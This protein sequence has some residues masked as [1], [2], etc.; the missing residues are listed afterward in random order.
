MD[1]LKKHVV[2][3]VKSLTPA[4]VLKSYTGRPGCMCGCKGTYRVTEATRAE[5]SKNRGYPYEDADVSARSVGMALRRIQERCTVED[6]LEDPNSSEYGIIVDDEWMY[7]HLHHQTPSG[8]DRICCVYLTGAA[9]KKL[10]NDSR[11]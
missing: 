2:E 4:D 1:I 11:R 6:I 5:A 10:Q 8:Q 3:L 7:V 9:Q